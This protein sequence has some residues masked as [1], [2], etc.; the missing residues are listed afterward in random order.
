MQ[1]LMSV[2]SVQMEHGA[3]FIVDDTERTVTTQVITL[4]I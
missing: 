3:D 1:G 4:D 2:D